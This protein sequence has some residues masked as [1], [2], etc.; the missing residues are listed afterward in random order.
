MS[1]NERKFNPIVHYANRL[2]CRPG[3]TFGPRVIDDYQWLYVEKGKGEITINGQVHPVESGCLLGYGPE[4]PHR[5]SADTDD[6]FVLFGLHFAPDESE[7]VDRPHHPSV[8]NIEHSPEIVHGSSA[9]DDVPN[10]LIPP[11][12]LV[13]SWAL[14]FFE[15]LVKEFDRRDEY[16]PLALR[17]AMIRLYVRL[18]RTANADSAPTRRNDIVERIRTAL[19]KRAEEDYRMEWLEEITGYSHDYAS[20]VYK[21]IAGTS[22]HSDHQRMRLQVAQ[23]YLETTGLSVTEIADTLQFGSIHYFCKWF[24]RM[25][26][27]SPSAYRSRKRMI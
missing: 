25:S 20:K 3:E 19:E 26:G 11:C 10:A 15:E 1:D 2:A 17:A 8:R 23:R 4:V 9:S 7:Y 12:S 14:P 16:A 5:I 6:P 18:R 13:G 24:R 22:P 21:E 27:L